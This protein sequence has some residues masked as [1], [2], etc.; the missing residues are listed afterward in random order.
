MGPS[1]ISQ[2][3]TIGERY[4]L[5][6]WGEGESSVRSAMSPLTMVLAYS[7][8]LQSILAFVRPAFSDQTQH[9]YYVDV[10]QHILHHGSGNATMAAALDFHLPRR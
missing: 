1:V 7:T 6:L 5:K 4:W 3:F 9:H 10:H 2:F 8:Q